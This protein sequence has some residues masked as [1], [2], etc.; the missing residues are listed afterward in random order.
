MNKKLTKF[1]IIILTL[2]LPFLFLSEIKARTSWERMKI[3]VAGIK[4][5]QGIVLQ[6]IRGTSKTDV[7]AVG[8]DKK[9]NTGIILHYDGNP[10]NEWKE[11][12][13]GEHF[14]NLNAV[15]KG[16]DNNFFAVGDGGTV[17][18]GQ[19]TQWKQLLQQDMCGNLRGVWASPKNT[20]FAVG[21]K[22]III[23]SM[24]GGKNWS[25]SKV[26]SKKLNAVWGVSEQKLFAVGDD[27]TI[28][29]SN[30]GGNKWELQNNP[31]TKKH[32]LKSIWGVS[33]SVV[34]TVGDHG[35]ILLHKD[36][37]WFE[38]ESDS[39][40]LYAI[41]ISP[42]PNAFILGPNGFISISGTGLYYI[43]GSICNA[44]SPL[45]SPQGIPAA[46]C[47][48]AGP[49]C[50]FKR[51]ADAYGQYTDTGFSSQNPLV[52]FHHDQYYKKE[53][54][55][56]LALQVNESGQNTTFLMPDPGVAIPLAGA[57]KCIAG[58][59][60]KRCSQYDCPLGGTVQ[61]NLHKLEG[62]EYSP[63]PIRNITTN[64][65][66]L[67]NFTNLDPGSYKIVPVAPGGC[68]L[69]PETTNVISIPQSSPP[70]AINFIDLTGTGTSACQ[71][72]CPNTY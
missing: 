16:A 39:A 56:L 44:C 35:T 55:I 63:T 72:P 60:S 23:K 33:P 3:N 45:P 65:M 43:K 64:S 66:G 14:T 30:N 53:E 26:T 28:L 9:T 17:L 18:L 71:C 15:C 2:L 41:W 52:R 20:I 10:E 29:F 34:F 69:S 32:N 61:V 7:F 42:N 4:E 51:Q 58:V 48:V 46:I 1:F 21:D 13:L 50:T 27:G 12:L 11:I 5:E 37:V 70:Q 38:I 68:V 67:Y 54:R 49:T 19:G 31:D 25:Y 22:G 47:E 24:D 62:C 40:D 6:G 36:N 59:I 8:R 57:E